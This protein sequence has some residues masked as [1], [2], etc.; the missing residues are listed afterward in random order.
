MNISCFKREKTPKYTEKQAENNLCKKL[1]NLLNRLLCCLLLDVEN[2][3]TYDGFNTQVNDNHYTNDISKCLDSVRFAEKEKYPD[4]VMVWVAISN[5][6]ISKPLFCPSKSET[7][8]WG[9]FI[10]ECLEKRLI[11]FTQTQIIFF[12]LI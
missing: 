12:G 10:N 5:R 7:D 8:N 3:F 1:A 4:K 11:S 2:F 9:I 6:S